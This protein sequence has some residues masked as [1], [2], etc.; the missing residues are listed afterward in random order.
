M[1]YQTDRIYFAAAW[2]C[3]IG[4]SIF[5]VIYAQS[6]LLTPD[7]TNYWQ[8]SRYLD[9]GYHDQAPLIAWVIKL[10]TTFLGHTELSVRL[11]SILSLAV[12]SFYLVAIAG[13]WFGAKTALNVAILSQ[14]IFEF[15]VGA[16]LATAD[17]IQAAGWAGA[18]YHVARAYE[19]HT[20]RQWLL[21]GAWFGFGILSK[22]TMVIFLPCVYLY[23]LS[24]AVH[25]NRLASVRPYVGLLIGCLMFL[26]VIIW[27]AQHGWSSARHVAYIGGAGETFSLHFKYTGDYLASQ[28]GLLSPLVFLLI[29]TAWVF[30]LR[31]KD[32][33]HK[34][35]ISYLFYTSFPMFALFTILSLHTRVYGNWPAAA[36]LTASIL[37]AVF[38]AGK[39][40]WFWT[41]GTAYLFTGLVLLQVVWPVLPIPATFDRTATELSGWDEIGQMADSVR[42]Q[43]PR[44]NNTFLFG[45]R[46][47]T[48]SEL[49]F[50][51]PGNPK[52]V[53]INKWRRPNVY[54]YWWQDEALVGMDGVGVTLLNIDTQ[55]RLAEVFEKVDPPIEL[56]ITRSKPF[57]K[58]PP[59][60]VKTAYIFKAY[61]FKGGIHWQPPNQQDIR[62]SDT[63]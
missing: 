20:W 24:S 57:S 1:K 22:Y 25:R 42:R 2:L 36:Y 59:E 33:P 19:N 27:N 46:Y 29:L 39:K 5:R 14:G 45:L 10:V 63:Y 58:L 53:S 7:E 38:F 26:P 62:V 52:T 48:A 13:R 3:I 12:A 31:K 17:G 43:M 34:W 4:F 32:G 9:W 35:I 8:W 61:G 11:P 21:G 51:A 23:G 56:I 40:I 60:A 55:S 15:N 6:F 49:A 47:Q 50:Y 54:D 18:T 16:L 30:V 41:I 44:P 37:I 28:A